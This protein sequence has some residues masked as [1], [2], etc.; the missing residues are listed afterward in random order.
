MAVTK[1]LDFWTAEETTLKGLVGKAQADLDKAHAARDVARAAVAKAAADQATTQAAIA[2]MKAQLAADL[3]P[4]DAAAHAKALRVLVVQLHGQGGAG[5]LAADDLAHAEAAAT[6]A[7]SQ[8]ARMTASLANATAMKDA[9]TKRDKARTDMGTA[10]AKAPLLGLKAAATAAQTGPEQVAAS[11]R[12][13]TDFPAALLSLLD[14]RRKVVLGH[15]TNVETAVSVTA[16]LLATQL[17][18]AGPAA[19]VE[20]VRPAYEAAWFALGDYV[21]TAPDELDRALRLFTSV[22]DATKP[23]PEE[24]NDIAT[25]PYQADGAAAIPVEDARNT[26]IGTLDT[27]AHALGKATVAAQAPDPSADVTATV[28]AQQTAYNN[29]KTDLETG[30]EPAFSTG[31]PSEKTLEGLWEAALADGEYALSAAFG[32]AGDVLTRLAGLDPAVLQ[33]ALDNAEKAL[34]DALTAAVK[35]DRTT[36]YLNDVLAEQTDLAV[37]FRAMRGDAITSLVRG[38]R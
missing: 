11:A 28:A 7:G 22:K 10:L 14:R 19:A 33:T 23:T 20:G 12:L 6:R 24:A 21:R 5:M 38:D 1:L 2:A 18:T 37:R 34:V 35:A 3:T 15:Q 9:A 13:T 26:A 4:A 36:Q 16:A 29:A 17:G 27:A 32:E 8:V 31:A 25:G 30:K